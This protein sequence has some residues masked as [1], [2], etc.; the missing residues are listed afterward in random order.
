MPRILIT[1]GCALIYRLLLYP[2]HDPNYSLELLLFLIVIANAFL[3]PLRF[4]PSGR[5][6]ERMSA[7]KVE[8]G[9]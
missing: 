9:R 7:R 5:S 3:Y 2:L 8:S 1:Y 4:R 6:G